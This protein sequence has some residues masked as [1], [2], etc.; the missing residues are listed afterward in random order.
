MTKTE[1][2][3]TGV[4]LADIPHTLNT[5]WSGHE[6]AEN[7]SSTLANI[8]SQLLWKWYFQPLISERSDANILTNVIQYFSFAYY[9]MQG[10][11]THI[12]IGVGMCEVV[13]VRL[14][15]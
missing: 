15:E 13:K 8:I 6:W 2:N 1:I 12:Q 11:N 7:H 14:H 3:I 10:A 5:I 4:G 9:A